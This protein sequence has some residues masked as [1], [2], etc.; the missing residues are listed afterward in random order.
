MSRGGSPGGGPCGLGPASSLSPVLPLGPGGLSGTVS[1]AGTSSPESPLQL[2]P[3]VGRQQAHS[4]SGEPA[5]SVSGGRIF[6]L[7]RR[8]VDA[9]VESCEG[10]PDDQPAL[11]SA[12][13][14]RPRP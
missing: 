11:V 7:L 2:S 8:W 13:C 4:V 5:D 9:G 3:T 1:S 14:C 12:L 10:Q 6:L